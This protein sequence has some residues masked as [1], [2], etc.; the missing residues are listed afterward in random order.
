MPKQIDIREHER[1]LREKLEAN[2][3]IGVL[4]ETGYEIVDDLMNSS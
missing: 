3:K 4:P 1:M 2:V